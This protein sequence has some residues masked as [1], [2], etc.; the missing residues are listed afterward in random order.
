VTRSR[1][2]LWRRKGR[3]ADELAAIEQP[4]NDPL[5]RFIE[6][7]TKITATGRFEEP[8]AATPKA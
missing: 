7:R 4:A 8:I 3:W 6:I 5:T 1:V 2:D